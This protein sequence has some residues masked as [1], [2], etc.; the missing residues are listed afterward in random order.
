MAVQDLKSK[1]HYRADFIISTVGMLA[2]NF[3]GFAAF[4]L[5][6]QSFPSIRGWS[7][8]E[9]LFLYS[10]SL[11]AQTPNQLFFDNNWSLRF[12]VFSG[13]FIK[14]C[15]RPINRYFYFISEVVDVKGFGQ[16]VFG[17][18]LFIYS[19]SKIGVPVNI[20]TILLAMGT[21]FSASLI[22]I[23]I[24]NFGAATC[25]WIINSGYI[26]TYLARFKD[27]A[28][29]PVTIFGGFFRVIFSF[30]IPIAYLSFYPSMFFLR[31]GEAGI[32]SYISP[33]VSILA[34]YLSY[35][36][37]MRGARKYSGTGS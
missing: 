25:F 28:K 3:A 37:W 5:I 15:F 12:A 9:M 33:V 31:P 35:K 22:M 24:I 19:W 13:D 16:L 17:L 6:F 14:F 32:L 36:F 7:Y 11:L 29:Y 4:W 27:Y 23:A 2:T 18:W 20:G 21:L 34:F 10:F 30:V 26:I 1:M 8:H